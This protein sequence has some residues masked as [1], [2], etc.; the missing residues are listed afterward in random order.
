MG[1]PSSAD[2]AA[3]QTLRRDCH[4]WLTGD[5][6]KVT[7]AQLQHDHRN[8]GSSP[9]TS[10]NIGAILK[11][12][13]R[14]HE[15]LGFY[16]N[17][18]C[19]RAAAATVGVHLVVIDA[20]EGSDCKDNPTYRKPLDQVSVYIPGDSN[21]HQLSKRKSWVNDIVPV[22]L[23]AQRNEAVPTD[24][25]YRVIIHNGEPAGSWAGHFD[26]VVVQ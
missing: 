24:P 26:A 18:A 4:G 13:N 10:S 23:R 7:D 8:A 22:L 9:F 6:K 20:H 12:K 21:V 16:C 11:G 2:Y 1:T 17:S 5:G 3:Q 15:P 19:L 25:L 14:P